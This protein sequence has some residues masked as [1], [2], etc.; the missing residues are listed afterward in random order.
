MEPAARGAGAMLIVA[1][2]A[3][4]RGVGA[5]ARGL[6]SAGATR[7]PWIVA[8]VAALMAA[9]A[10][11]VRQ[12]VRTGAREIRAAAAVVWTGLRGV[13]VAAAAGHAVGRALSACVRGVVSVLVMLGTVVDSVGALG[14][15]TA[16]GVGRAV[17]AGARGAVSTVAMLGTVFV[18]LGVMVATAAHDIWRTV[19]VGLRGIAVAVES[20]LRALPSGA[21]FTV[22]SLVMVTLVLALWPISYEPPSIERPPPSG[23]VES[24]ERTPEAERARAARA[25]SPGGTR[26]RESLRSPAPPAR[27]PV[28]FTTARPPSDR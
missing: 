4:V 23:I 1:G 5:G 6:A 7:G 25:V 2:L 21:V 3:I 27:G 15:A 20:A 10:R 13:G 8:A 12:G 11:T 9:A 16:R 24:L 22:L 28:T 14:T 17:S 18:S 19:R 26:R